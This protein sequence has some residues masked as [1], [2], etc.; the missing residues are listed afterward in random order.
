MIKTYYGGND[1][2]FYIGALDNKQHLNLSEQA[3]SKVEED[4]HMFDDITKASNLSG[5][6]N[7]IFT[8]YYETALASLSYRLEEKSEYYRSF[9]SKIEVTIDKS[10]TKALIKSMLDVYTKETLD[11][12][13]KYPKGIG[14]KFRINNENVSILET[15]LDDVY[16]EGSISLYLK[17]IFEEYTSLPLHDRE[18]IYFNEHITKIKDAIKNNSILS[19]SLENNRNYLVKPY[20]VIT[21]KNASF[22]Y[23]VCMTKLIQKDL[24]DPYK[25]G[26][27]RV[28][29]IKNIR[30]LKSPSGK[31]T[32]TEQKELTQ[33][34]QAKGPQFLSGDDIDV[35]IRLTKEGIKKYNNQIT[36][37]P[38]FMEIVNDNEYQFRC[39]ESQILYYFLK[40]GRD[41][42]VVSP[43]YLKDKF[44]RF[45]ESALNNYKAPAVSE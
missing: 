41:V 19:I 33:L 28:S 44:K 35:T 34:L 15:S 43:N 11:D 14:R 16:Y 8:N 25:I 4:M 20:D 3:W 31:L 30:S 18:K 9:F 5:F 39:T 1:M 22:N 17:Y 32:I 37:R 21:D 36:L 45:Y 2:G 38:L 10:T 29:R 26:T 12:L 23:L 27:F 13:S 42:T 6:L 40:F 7:R 24:S